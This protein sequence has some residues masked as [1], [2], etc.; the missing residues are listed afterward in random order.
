[1]VVKSHS[2]DKS[3]YSSKQ[4]NKLSSLIQPLVDQHKF[5]GSI[6]YE[7]VKGIVSGSEDPN[8]LKKALDLFA[9]NDI[10]IECD[11]SNKSSNE[12]LL[13]GT[14]SWDP[15]KTYLRNVG[16]TKL[17]TKDEEVALA[18]QIEASK[19][20][21]VLVVLGVPSVRKKLREK[22]AMIKAGEIASSVLLDL[23]SLD[24]ASSEEEVV[25]IENLDVEPEETDQKHTAS[26]VALNALTQLEEILDKADAGQD[27]ECDYSLVQMINLRRIDEA[28][29]GVYKL[30]ND[31]SQT[32]QGI[33]NLAQRM[34]IPKNLAQEYIN[35]LSQDNPVVPQ[36]LEEFAKVA[37]SRSLAIQ[38]IKERVVESVELNLEDLRKVAK[39]LRSSYGKMRRARSEMVNANL[40]LVVSL[41]KKYLNRGL[42]FLDLVQ[43]GNL[44]LIKAVEKFNYKKGFKFST[45]SCWW[46][47]QA[48][49]RA[50][51][52]RGRLVRL[53]VHMLE[54]RNRMIRAASK[55][56]QKHGVEPTYQQLSEES[57][58]SVEKIQKTYMSCKDLVVHVETT[59]IADGGTGD[60]FL[61]E[62]IKDDT[63]ESPLDVA[64]A[65]DTRAKIERQL[66][67][68]NPR[69]ERIIRMRN[70][71]GVENEIDHTLESVGKALGVTRER[72][73]Q[74]ENRARNIM[75]DPNNAYGLIGCLDLHT[76]QPRA[77]A[78]TGASQTVKEKEGNSCVLDAS[79]NECQGRK[80]RKK[81][82]ETTETTRAKKPPQ[83]EGSSVLLD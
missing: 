7:K 25:E 12:N 22:I 57:G 27:I 18:K 2:D 54:A 36:G 42:L 63:A 37:Y 55:F 19:L 15:V 67:K 68:L 3:D 44:G 73:R 1:M 50:I 80:R 71:F 23:S 21:V 4:N 16:S 29:E 34:G 30:Y 8:A 66:T 43:E 64:I 26:Q 75:K 52:D 28:I 82:Q 72:V 59:P 13:E 81:G 62:F 47:K 77:G 61:S 49:T 35:S 10:E 5:S 33:L 46:I 76:Y 58:F 83:A 17:L 14:S 40:R 69:E 56:F 6:N 20:D 39:A 70:G 53:P 79:P 41:A 45:Y 65:A 38:E 78:T 60:G 24:T 32:E 74:V 9:E 31:L 51:S 11:P 48:I